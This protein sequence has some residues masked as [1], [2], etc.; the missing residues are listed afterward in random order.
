V[1]KGDESGEWRRLHNKELHCLYHSPKIVRVIKSRRLRWTGQVAR[2][3]EGRSAFN[4][5]N[6]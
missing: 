1:P 5:F 2:K 4:K 3:E 6:R